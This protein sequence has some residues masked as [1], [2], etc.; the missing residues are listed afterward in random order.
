MT[1]WS[2]DSSQDGRYLTAAA[3][4]G[5]ALERLARAYEADPDRRRDLLQEVHLALWR[6][7]AS[8]NGAC[9]MRTWVYRVAHNAATSHVMR[10]RRARSQV[11]VSVEE[12]EAMPDPAAPEAAAGDRQALDRL[13]ALVQGL[14]PLDRQVILS[15]LEGLEAAEIGEIT[16]ISAGN[17]ATKIHRIKNVLARRF[18]Q[19][20]C[21]GE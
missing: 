18:H 2:V 19:G 16:G 14:K 17:V 3:E 21:H 15:Y 6:S 11:L 20:A 1:T 12:L 13:L 5:P 10:E 8:W 9:S 7:F 4:F